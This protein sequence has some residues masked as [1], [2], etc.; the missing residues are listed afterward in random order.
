MAG[1]A[2]QLGARLSRLWAFATRW[3]R[4][5]RSTAAAAAGHEQ[6]WLNGDQV[7]WSLRQRLLFGRFLFG[8]SSAFN[9]GIMLLLEN[10]SS[11]QRDEFLR[12][13]YFHVVGGSTNRLY[14]IT[15][16]RQVNVFQLNERK[17]RVCIWC[18][19]PAGNLVEGDVML[20]QKLALEL[21][22]DQALSI[23][24]RLSNYCEPLGV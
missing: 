15:T 17:R 10:L 18:F 2:A 7:S 22:E 13:G 1:L 11:R 8:R 19:Y 9:R 3:C 4:A 5:G 23:A 24:N 16:G 14:R 21:F 6:N 12:H 20:A